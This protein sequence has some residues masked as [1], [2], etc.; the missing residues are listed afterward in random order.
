M[1]AIVH[2]A[3]ILE[4]RLIE[5]KTPDQFRRVFETKVRGLENILAATG[6]ENLRHLILF[7]SVTGRMGNRGQADYAMANEVLNKI[8]Q[9]FSAR[10]APCRVVAINWGPWDGGMVTPGLKREFQRRGVALIPVELGARQ[11][12]A[13]MRTADRRS[14][15]VVIGGKGF[16]IVKGGHARGAAGKKPGD[17]LSLTFQRDV[18]L[19]SHPVLRSHVIGGKPVVPLA[20][21]TEW[22]GHG[23]LHENPGLLLQG[24]DD[25]RVLKGIKLDG[26]KKHVRLLAGRTRKTGEAYEVPVELRDGVHSNVEVV[27]SKA[28]AIL[29]DTLQSAPEFRIPENLTHQPYNRPMQQVYEQILFHGPDLHGIQQ[30]THLSSEGM[31]AQLGPAPAPSE[32]LKE[33]LRN[34]WLADPLA[35]DA[36]FQMATVWCYEEKG[37]VSLPSYC[38]AYRQYRLRFPGDGL[39][40]VLEIDS[41]GN[42]KM[43]GTITFLDGDGIVVARISGY[44][45]VMDQSLY[46]A[47]KPAA[48]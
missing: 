42:H 15:E 17:D 32:W 14:V 26:P 21:M 10:S 43:K 11:V 7:S 8:A 13:E 5:D 34:K 6:R 24:L 30:I 28:K 45:A 36:A 18:D 3:G 2:G 44:E 37:V 1:R 19:G 9:Q 25:I 31:I 33:P 29:V 41:A 22:F 40:A 46:R 38:A 47:F 20:L 4:D 12:V 39:T 16:S 35:L 48:A 27:H 23:A